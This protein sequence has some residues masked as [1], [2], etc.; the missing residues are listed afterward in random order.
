MVVQR[1]NNEL[2]IYISFSNGRMFYGSSFMG[3]INSALA[4]A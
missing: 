2:D 4:H 3:A 1:I